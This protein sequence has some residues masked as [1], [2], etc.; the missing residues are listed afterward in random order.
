MATTANLGRIIPYYRG[1]FNIND[2]YLS[3]HEVTW[4]DGNNYRVKHGTAPPIGTLPTDTTYWQPTIVLA[5]ILKTYRDEVIELVAQ[6]DHY[7]HIGKDTN[8]TTDN[9]Y[10]RHFITVLS[11]SSINCVL[12]NTAIEGMHFKVCQEGTG[13]VN[14]LNNVGATI[15]ALG[16]KKKSAG[17]YAVV[18]I[19]CIRNPTGDAAIWSVS[20]QTVA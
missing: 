15:N 20:G 6:F 12:H 14:V 18:D 7:I 13:V 16:N 1:N 10:N 3:L 5:E 2:R 8:F 17:Q 19:V 4:T 9:T 11:S